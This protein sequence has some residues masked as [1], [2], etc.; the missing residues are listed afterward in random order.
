MI[1]GPMEL[2]TFSEENKQRIRS[3]ACELRQKHGAMDW[4]ISPVELIKFE[5][6]DYEEYNLNE[7]GFLKKLTRGIKKISK[8]VRAAL[9]PREKV[10]LIDL[11]LHNA[12]KP[13]GQAH[14]L[15]HQKIPEH[16]K[17][18]YVCSEADLNPKTRLE[19]EFE[20]NIYASETLF[21][22][23]LMNN[24]YQKYPLSLETVLFLKNVS[25]ASIHSSTIKYVTGN[26]K[27]CCLLILEPEEDEEGNKGLRLQSQIWSGPWYNKYKGRV[28]ADKQLFP[29]QHNL[30]GVV[31]SGSAGDIVKNTIKSRNS[32]LVFQAHTFY[33]QYIVLALIF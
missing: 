33:N 17:I 18:L 25:G 12:K 27:E 32:N 29:P 2:N 23:H 9:V 11:H 19:M 3:L 1:V 30:S 5:G 28:F 20:A 8:I 4:G 15:G 24:I 26:D 7:K 21:P 10:V 22:A 13:F 6:L 14:E 16:R 31:F